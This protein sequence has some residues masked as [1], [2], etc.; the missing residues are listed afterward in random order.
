METCCEEHLD[1]ESS[2]SESL[3]TSSANEDE[4]HE[5]DNTTPTAYRGDW[6]NFTRKPKMSSGVS[7]NPHPRYWLI[8]GKWYDLEPFAEK[9]PGGRK[10][11]LDARDRFDDCTFV[12]ESHHPD[13]KKARAVLNKYLV[14]GYNE[15]DGGVSLVEDRCHV[16]LL[17]D[18][19]FYSV[20]RRR[21]SAYLKENGGRDP[22]WECLVLFWSLLALYIALWVSLLQTGS[23]LA[24][25]GCILVGPPLG[26]F[27]HNWLHMP[28]YRRMALVLDV[29]GFSSEQWMRDHNLQHHMYTNTEKDNHFKG[30][31]PFLVTDPTVE[32]N[33]FQKHISP[34]LV[35][36]VLS[37][38]MWGNYLIHTLALL[39][40]EE[41][42]SIGK[43][44]IPIELVL[45]V[46]TQGWQYG[47]FLA[48]VLYGS[49]SVVYFTFAL[50][51]HN[52]EKCVDV[53]QRNSS[54]DFGIAQ[55]N[56]SADW[57]VGTSFIG[58]LPY[59]WLNYH[60][61]HHLFPNVCMS[62]HPAIQKILLETVEEFD[63]HYETSDIVTLYKEI[64]RT[65][66]SP[67]SYKLQL[68]VYAGGI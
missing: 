56:S 54:A 24:L 18:D 4:H 11:L 12:F 50:M 40:G 64:T 16:K 34:R 30:T 6:D 55:L 22:T 65:F 33:F 14:K 36:V 19:A 23:L 57:A 68:E 17:D 63:V 26:G 35:P 28:K 49:T 52:A 10:M 45:L 39:K 20:L 31:D 62:K 27:G 29:L 38:G 42:F 1:A 60:T 59:L 58:S 48:Y 2:A 51:N 44:F 25:F 43:L 21:V 9:H 67:Y 3:E 41:S 53:A 8:G 5:E 47:L 46:Y 32:R 66:A 61:V 15:A 37:F 13:Y 7:F